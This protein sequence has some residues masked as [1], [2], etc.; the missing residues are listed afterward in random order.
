MT[1]GLI[2]KFE[3]NRAAQRRR[4]V[5]ARCRVD[6]VRLV[7]RFGSAEERDTYLAASAAWDDAGRPNVP[8][9]LVWFR[10]QVGN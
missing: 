5:N 1:L 7:L 10:E 3:A 2:R 6:E 8:S 4:E 9:L